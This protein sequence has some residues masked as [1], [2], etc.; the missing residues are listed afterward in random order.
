MQAHQQ[1]SAAQADAEQQRKL[2][3]QQTEATQ[4]RDSELQQLRAELKALRKAESRMQAELRDRESRLLE[5]QAALSK[6]SA[7]LPGSR[8]LA[9]V[10][11]SLSDDGSTAVSS[12]V[13]STSAADVDA[14][15][16][17]DSG[18]RAAAGG[19]PLTPAGSS[20]KQRGSKGGLGAGVGGSMGGGGL[21]IMTPDQAAAAQ[22]KEWLSASQQALIEAQDELLA[23]EAEIKQL[24]QQLQQQQQCS[25][26]QQQEDG[27]MQALKQPRQDHHQQEAQQ[28][29]EDQL[30]KLR[31]AVNAA[32]AERDRLASDF[33]GL[34]SELMQL[35]LQLEEAD[36]AR[37][38]AVASLEALQ[39]QQQQ[40]GEEQSKEQQVDAEA[41]AAAAERAAAAEAEL[42]AALSAAAKAS[43]EVE[44]LHQQLQQLQDK[45]QQQE[46]QAGQPG[47]PSA[48][49]AAVDKQA[50]A[51]STAA[52]ATQGGDVELLQANIRIHVLQEELEDTQDSMRVLLQLVRKSAAAAAAAVLQNGSTHAAVAA[53][54]AGALSGAEQQQLQDMLSPSA[55]AVECKETSACKDTADVFSTEAVEGNLAAAAADARFEFGV[56]HGLLQKLECRY[57]TPKSLQDVMRRGREMDLLLSTALQRVHAIKQ[58][59]GGGGCICPTED[60]YRHPVRAAQLAP[61]ATAAAASA[62][63]QKANGSPMHHQQ[64]QQPLHSFALVDTAGGM[65]QGEDGF[66]A[67]LHSGDGWLQ[68]AVAD[69]ASGYGAV[70]ESSVSA[71]GYSS[72][73]QSAGGGGW[74]S[75]AGQGPSLGGSC[76]GDALQ[77]FGGH[78]MGGPAVGDGVGVLAGG[79]VGG[80]APLKDEGMGYDGLDGAWWASSTIGE[81]ERVTELPDFLV[82]K[83]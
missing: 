5:A 30:Q 36:S 6:L 35:R 25:E 16:T 74:D 54:A 51:Q 78:G 4:L 72:Y 34:R 57:S 17:A 62:G 26:P 40:Q 22:Y 20:K 8:Q 79:G 64:Q 15:D 46:Q 13:V 2:A 21:N 43:A 80:L 59:A 69:H 56:L 18:T 75:W 9:S 7:E 81:H 12:S 14:T 33:D 1:V 83:S 11:E 31:A 49:N 3:A 41:A 37:S 23:R 52:P 10:L 45:Q 76:G 61:A 27:D 70:S 24:K 58:E 60:D 63:Q 82:K 44:S 38:S 68:G 65:M 71:S 28:E 67:G 39:Q 48:A 55:A 32:A 50:L 42:Q 73:T 29:Q 53:A 19:L 47:S 66:E 77:S